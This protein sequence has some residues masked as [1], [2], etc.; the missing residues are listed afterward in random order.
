MFLPAYIPVFYSELYLHGLTES[1]RRALLHHADLIHCK[2]RHSKQ[3]HQ[4]LHRIKFN[5]DAGTV[6]AV[7]I[8]TVFLKTMLCA[9]L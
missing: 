6:K 9:L 5:L 8:H 3:N 4:E 1:S 7:Q 2:G